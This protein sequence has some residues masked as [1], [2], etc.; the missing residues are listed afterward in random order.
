MAPYLHD[1]V[2][3]TDQRIIQ[4]L[5]LY[6]IVCT[7]LVQS[8]YIHTRYWAV[9]RRND[10]NRR[11]RTGTNRG[12]IEPEIEN[13][14]EEPNRKIGRTEPKIEVMLHISWKCSFFLLFFLLTQRS[15]LSI[16]S[17]NFFFGFPPVTEQQQCR[18]AM[19]PIFCVHWTVWQVLVFQP[20]K[21]F[22]T[23]HGLV[24]P[25]T[26]Q[27]TDKSGPI[28]FL[29]CCCSATP[30][31]PC[32]TRKVLIWSYETVLLKGE[33]AEAGEQILAKPFSEQTKSDP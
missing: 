12:A 10:T 19:G 17:F 23:Q 21:F 8:S 4:T 26:V 24:T 7:I 14:P 5:Y 1:M 13:E 3:T 20:F 6:I 28:S 18:R 30:G 11:K 25:N 15:S 33:I 9:C 2:L 29:H 22:F 16:S 31:K 27:W 32:M